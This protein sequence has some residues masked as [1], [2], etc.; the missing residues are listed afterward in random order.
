LIGATFSF[1]NVAPFLLGCTVSIDIVC[2]IAAA[3]SFLV[4]ALGV[5]TGRI[6][7]M[8]LAFFFL[9]LSLIV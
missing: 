2:F 3:I 1:E 4:K 5:N 6:D 8:N 9:A 7:C